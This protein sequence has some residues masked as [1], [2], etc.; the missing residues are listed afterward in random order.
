MQSPPKNTPTFLRLL[1]DN[2]KKAIQRL[3]ELMENS[4]NLETSRKACVDI[5]KLYIERPRRKKSTPPPAVLEPLDDQTADR[6]LRELT[7]E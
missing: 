7:D 5:L 2:A 1:S 4:D 3:S 6:L